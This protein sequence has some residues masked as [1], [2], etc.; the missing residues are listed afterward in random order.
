MAGADRDFTGYP[1]STYLPDESFCIGSAN[2]NFFR[3]VG[4][5]AFVGVT[6]KF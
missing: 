5:Q 3:V 1:L 6:A 2:S 4:A